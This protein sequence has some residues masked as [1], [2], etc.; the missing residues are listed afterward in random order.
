MLPVHH[1]HPLRVEQLLWSVT[2]YPLS[3][4][5]RHLDLNGDGSISLAE[6]AALMGELGVDGGGA[7]AAAELMAAV[8]EADLAADG[9]IDFPAFL[10]F[11]RRVRSICNCSL[12]AYPPQHAAL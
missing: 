2:S 12:H 1:I 4:L 11:C 5:S 9:G 10:S 8:S 7:D 6:M 3:L